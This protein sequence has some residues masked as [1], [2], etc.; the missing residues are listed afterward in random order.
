MKG[1]DDVKNSLI[2]DST[3]NIF[4]RI[5]FSNEIKEFK[6]GLEEHIEKISNKNSNYF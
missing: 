1:L 6:K 2:V 5:K 4:I 3:D